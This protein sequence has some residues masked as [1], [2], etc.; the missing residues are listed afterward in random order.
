MMRRSR[1]RV[2]DNMVL[3]EVL[4]TRSVSWFAT[5]TVA[6]LEEIQPVIMDVSFRGLKKT[7]THTSVVEVL[8]TRYIATLESISDGGCIPESERNRACYINLQMLST[9]Y[10]LLHIA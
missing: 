5:K 8:E 3:Y 6:W 1:S 7:E 2:S 9:L 4:H 10:L